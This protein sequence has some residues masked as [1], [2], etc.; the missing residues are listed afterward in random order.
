MPPKKILK[1]VVKKVI[2]EEFKEEL[3]GGVKEKEVKTSRNIEELI[4]KT[5]ILTEDEKI[6]ELVKNVK[7][8]TE[9]EEESLALIYELL[10]MIKEE[11][12][13]KVMKMKRNNKKEWIFLQKGLE[14]S[15]RENVFRLKV[16]KEKMEV[17]SGL[18]KCRRCGSNRTVSMEIQLRRADE[19]MS[20]VVT[21]IDCEF[22]WIIS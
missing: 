18:F 5:G 1:G 2:K 10:G 12:F 21:C 6:N 16:N 15:L 8:L 22:K 14:K 4:K 13:E 19:P 7:K 11:G 9:N 20:I 17:K 3:K